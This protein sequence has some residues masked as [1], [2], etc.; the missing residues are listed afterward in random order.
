MRIFTLNCLGNVI[1]K[2]GVSPDSKKA[3]AIQ[4]RPASPNVSELHQ[5]LGMINYFGKFLPNLS[6]VISPMSESLK[7][8]STWI[9]SHRQQ[10]AFEKV[11]A[12]V[13]TAPVLAFYDMNKPTVVS[14]DAS[15]YGLGGVLLQK[16]GGQLRP[17]SFAFRTL[18]DSELRPNRKRMFSFSAI[19][20][21][22]G[23]APFCQHQESRPLAMSNTRCPR[24]T[25]FPSLCACSESILTNLIGSGL[26][27]LCLQ[28]HSK[29]E[30]RCTGPELAIL[31]ADQKE[32][33]FWGREC[34][35]VG[36]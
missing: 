17:V 21:P 35:S 19:L 23:R 15:S 25:D 24:F 10:E 29:P 16:H 34:F 12:M 20:V 1:S 8:E 4:E 14:A 26:N 36:M 28:S 9:W 6:H 27:L 5:V 32:R 2:E 7:S 18:T 33:G 13:T 3:K 31:C 22:R 30:C 11:K